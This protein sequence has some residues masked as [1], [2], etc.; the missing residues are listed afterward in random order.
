HGGGSWRIVALADEVALKAVGIRAH[1]AEVA[2]ALQQLVGNARRDQYGITSGHLQRFPGGVAEADAG[3]TAK[4]ADH[5][6]RSAVKVRE[7]IDRITPFRRP[8]IGAETFLE[9]L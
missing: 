2:L 4:R 3:A 8:A 5:F 6:V 9:P 1:P 7:G